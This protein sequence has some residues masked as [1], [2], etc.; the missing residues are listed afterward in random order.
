MSRDFKFEHGKID[1]STIARTADGNF[2]CTMC[3]GK[4]EI[5]LKAW[6]NLPEE[7]RMCIVCQGTGYLIE[8]VLLALG[9]ERSTSAQYRGEFETLR[10]WVRKNSTC[11]TCHGDQMKTMGGCPCKECGLE[12][13]QP[14]GG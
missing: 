3:K 13:R 7:T 12:G 5:H 10:D 4:R 6:K 8:D 1:W 11:K 9:S 2:A 14:W